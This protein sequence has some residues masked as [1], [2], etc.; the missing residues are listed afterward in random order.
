LQHLPS[1]LDYHSACFQ[2]F[3]FGPRI[4]PNIHHE[5]S[6]NFRKFFYAARREYAA[7]HSFCKFAA[8]GVEQPVD[9]TF[10]WFVSRI[11][12]AAAGT[13]SERELR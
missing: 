1:G 7:E 2:P 4:C 5:P 12:T 9:I 10:E 8:I 11:V 3:S 6:F 13:S